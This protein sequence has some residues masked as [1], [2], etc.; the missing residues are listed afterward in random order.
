MSDGYC[1][2]TIQVEEPDGTVSVI[3][4]FKTEGLKIDTHG[5]EQ[6]RFVGGGGPA[7][8]WRKMLDIEL[9]LRG[10][11]DPEQGVIYRQTTTYPQAKE[12]AQ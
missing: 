4:F 8:Y 11:L 9:S 12:V 5:V 2:I 3:E 1:K 7:S 6:E 10:F